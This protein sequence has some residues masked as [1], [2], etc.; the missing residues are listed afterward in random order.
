VIDDR[1]LGQRIQPKYLAD[2]GL[3]RFSERFSDRRQVSLPNELYYDENHVN[4]I[5][6]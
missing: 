5:F 6:V 4:P 2:S 1:H 3:F